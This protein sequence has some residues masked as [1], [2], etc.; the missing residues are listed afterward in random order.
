MSVTIRHATVA[1]GQAV[2]E[3]VNTHARQGL[4]LPRSQSAVYQAIRDFVVAE[5]HGQ[6]VGCGALHITWGDLGEVRSLAV[7]NGQQGRGLGR[8]IV[9]TLLREARQLGLPRVFALTYQQQF[10]RRLGFQPTE[11]DTLPQKIWADCVDCVRFPDCDEEA[12]ITSLE[13][14]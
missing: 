1:D 2:Y 3:L 13:S 6:I 4:M 8:Q 12:M 5:D 10:F 14:P 11:K 7:A 9:E